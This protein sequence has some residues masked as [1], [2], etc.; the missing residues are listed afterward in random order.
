MYTCKCISAP[1]L[2]SRKKKKKKEL[3][4]WVQFRFSFVFFFG[5][6]VKRQELRSPLRGERDPPRAWIWSFNF[7]FLPL[8]TPRFMTESDEKC[9]ECL[10]L[11]VFARTFTRYVRAGKGLPRLV[12]QFPRVKTTEHRGHHSLWVLWRGVYQQESVV[13][14]SG[15]YLVSPK[16][17]SFSQGWSHVVGQY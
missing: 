6:V 12:L 7:S 8:G 4:Q 10:R 15:A 3:P 14:S 9:P 16:G 1:M 2:C 13:S 5:R 17:C 11:S